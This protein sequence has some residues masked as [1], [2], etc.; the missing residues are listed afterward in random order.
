MGVLHFGPS[1]ELRMHRQPE[2]A[3][4][5]MSIELLPG[6]QFDH[7]ERFCSSVF[8]RSS[9]WR[10]RERKP[11]NQRLAQ[12]VGENNPAISKF[13]CIYFSASLAEYMIDSN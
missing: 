7:G 11:G 10:I 5:E 2:F 13:S 3:K 8:D 6:R 1:K 12:R 4:A 9:G